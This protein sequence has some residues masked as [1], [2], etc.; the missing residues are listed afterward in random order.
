MKLSIL[1]ST[2]ALGAFG[3]SLFAQSDTLK[4]QPSPT[5][6]AKSKWFDNISIRGYAQARYNRLFETNSKLKCEQCDKS[7]GEGGGFFLRRIRII[8]YGQISERVYFYIQPDF[9]SSAGTTNHIAQIRDAY[10]DIGLDSKNEFRLRIGQS[11]VPFGFE[12]MQSSQNRMALDRNDALN[13]ALSNERDLGVFFYWAPEKIRKRFSAL[14][15]DGL[16]GSGDY[17]VF[18]FGAYNGQTANQPEKNN[19]PHIVTRITYPFQIKNQIIEPAIQAYTGKFVL[20]ST[21]A[22]TKLAPNTE[23]LDQRVAGSFIL[24]P[25]PF[26]IMA[27]YN[28]GKGPEFNTAT[29]S[30]ETRK[31]KGGYITLSYLT[32]FNKQILI[33]F[34]R[35][36][37]YEGGKKHE[38]DARS[39][40]VKELEIGVEW[41]PSANFELVA[42]YT[43]SERRFE[44]YANQ[45]NFQK[46]RLLRLQAQV[47]F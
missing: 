24:Y 16:K 25:Q 35:A 40:Q 39:Y 41:Q 23:Y 10:M 22:K 46:G 28:V 27:E 3:N 18:A 21:S 17:G 29:D 31:L 6:K 7:I 44:D 9:A 26:G 13:S 47:N 34:V 38:L 11:K 1:I 12:N 19:K 2:I 42:M 8:F 32:K 5:Q 20:L 15:K 33:P 37:Q 43:F 45:N 14:V 30:V 36:Q 4:L